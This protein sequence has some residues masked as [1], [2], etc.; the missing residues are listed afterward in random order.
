MEQLIIPVLIIVAAV[1]MA[2]RTS[3]N[4]KANFVSK[5][6]QEKEHESYIIS[7]IKKSNRI[8]D[9]NIEKLAV[10]RSKT[11]LTDPYGMENKKTWIEKEIPYFIEAHILPKLSTQENYR[12]DFELIEKISKII[13]NKA[14]R[15]E[16]KLKHFLKFSNS[17]TGV[18]FE[19]FCKKKLESE[20]W[21]VSETKLSGDQGIDLIISRDNRNIGIQCK[22][23]S[24]PVG[25][26]AVQE[27]T[28]GI[29]FYH[30]SEGIVITNN[31]YTKSAIVLAKSNNIKLLHYTETTII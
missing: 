21:K 3:R 14:K 23:Y 9:Q 30:L 25:N 2:V 12:V 22:K 6:D 15:K 19:I 10:Q 8:I 28:A 18:E 31:T 7:I 13:D 16:K 1:I 11:V 29:A 24:K 27:V 17:F 4:N 5:E 26:S 20:G